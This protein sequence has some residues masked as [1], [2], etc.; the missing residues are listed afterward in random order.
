MSSSLL[1]VVAASQ[2][3]AEVCLDLDYKTYVISLDRWDRWKCTLLLMFNTL[4]NGTSNSGYGVIPN[5]IYYYCIGVIKTT[6]ITLLLILNYFFYLS[7][8]TLVS[9]G[10]SIFAASKWRC[11]GLPHKPLGNL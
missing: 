10:P 3:S 2:T 7:Q 4:W 8:T 6:A 1:S 11:V 9:N 5:K